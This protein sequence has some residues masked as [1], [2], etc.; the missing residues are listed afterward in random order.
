MI[1]TI[2][3]KQNYFEV[4]DFG[5][6]I[7]NCVIKGEKMFFLSKHAK[8]DNTI[9]IRGGIP[10]VFPNFGFSNNNLPKHGYLRN[11]KWNFVRSWSNEIE[12]GITFEFTKIFDNFN[13]EYNLKYE[14]ILNENSLKNNLSIHNNSKYP[15][16]F[17]M[18]YHN[19]FKINLQDFKCNSFSNKKFYNQLNDKNEYDYNLLKIDNEIDRIYDNIN[20]VIFY[21]NSNE[22]KLESNSNFMVLWNPWIQKSKLLKDFGDEEF[23]NM[24]C[25]EPGI[26]YEINPN[27]DFIFWQKIIIQ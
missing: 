25:F 22:I 23:K 1:Y 18:L 21:S 13:Y 20:E 16:T 7:L 5:A 6:N 4:S 12:A 19:Y 26:K 8:L 3:Y 14:I 9:P 10:L 11:N 17:D 2:K 24:V 27:E 15:F